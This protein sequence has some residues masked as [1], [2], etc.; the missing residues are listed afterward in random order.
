MAEPPTSEKEL[1]ARA[2]AMAGRT[3]S[4]LAESVGALAPPDMKRHKGWIGNLIERV[5]GA[6]AASRDEPDFEALGIELKT[7]PIDPQGR[8]LETTFVATVPLAEV[9]EVPW[10]RCRVRRKLARVLWVPVLGLREIAPADRRVGAPVLWSP[11]EEEEA[12]LRQDWEELAGMIGRGDIE[13][14]TGRLGRY[15]QV[16]PKAAHGGVRRRSID[17][18]G[19]MIQTLPRGFYLRTQ[20]TAQILRDSFAL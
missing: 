11:S 16:R 20:F 5:L 8:P 1:F 19:H 15:L 12:L 4:D 14:I 7:I 6:T 2:E 13:R 10:E 3:L 18:E 17:T 9:G